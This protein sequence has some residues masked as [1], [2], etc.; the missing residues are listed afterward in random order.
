MK[1]SNKNP[2]EVFGL[3][4][5]LVK[6]LNNETLF[7]IIKGIYRILQMQYHPDKGGDPKKALEINL[8][9][10]ALN[11]EKDPLSFQRY[12]NYYIKRLSKKTLKSE[13]E[14]CTETLRK[15]KYQ[16]ELLKDRFWQYLERGCSFLEDYYKQGIA[17]RLKLLDIVFQ[18]NYAKYLGFKQ[19]DGVFIELVLGKEGI[20]KRLSG[21]SKY[22]FYKNYRLLGIVKRSHIEPWML[23]EQDLRDEKKFFKNY[24]RKETFIKEVL[25]FLTPEIK[26]NSYLFLYNPSDP[27]RVY[28]E[29]LIIK[30]EEV[31]YSEFLTFYYSSTNH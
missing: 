4:P 13:L 6:E 18:I 30:I 21:G 1:R 24:L 25:F 14:K 20:L 28:L 29:G 9:F 7:K 10:S 23:V 27:Q 8:S 2:F 22:F 11:Y 16:Q 3:T 26:N 19:K 15:L 17:L 12:K 31:S 5:Q